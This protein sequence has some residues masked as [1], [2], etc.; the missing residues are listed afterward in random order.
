MDSL[1]SCKN[2]SQTFQEP[3][4]HRSGDIL[5]NREQKNMTIESNDVSCLLT[6]LFSIGKELPQKAREDQ[7]YILK[8]VHGEWF[9]IEE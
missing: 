2:H 9:S 1:I 4:Y 6:A 7:A 8:L 5:Q 3:Q